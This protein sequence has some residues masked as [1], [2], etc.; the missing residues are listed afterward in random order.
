V[1]KLSTELDDAFRAAALRPTVQRYAVLE[2]LA[3]SPIHATA[4][5][6]FAAINR[7]DPRASRATVYNNL[8]DLTQAGLVR[9]VISDGTAA[10]F[11]ANLHRHHHFVCDGCGAVEDVPWFDLPPAT[12]KS[13][14]RGRKVRNYEIVFRGACARCG[15]GGRS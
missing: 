9:E 4:E 8:R 12:G 7:H 10:R 5:E 1:S 14:L 2:F 11:D 6:I 3:K 13:Q 15:K